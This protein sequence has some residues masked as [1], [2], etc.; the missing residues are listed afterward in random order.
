KSPEEQSSAMSEYCRKL[1]QIDCFDFI[2][3]RSTTGEVDGV[4]FVLPFKPT[5]RTRGTHRVYLRNMLLSEK[6]D[7]LLPEWAFFVRCVINANDLRPTA[8]RESFYQNRK[9]ETA[10][11][12]LGKCLRRYLVQLAEKDPRRMQ[13][14]I[15]LHYLSM[16]AL[17][18][19]DD[20][21]YKLFI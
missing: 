7:D 2:P 11:E 12:S 4:A 9:L 13:R 16:K 14:L 20:D 19:E 21:F 1:F 3:L 10:R 8:S 15:E 18:V 6:A 17:A 5:H